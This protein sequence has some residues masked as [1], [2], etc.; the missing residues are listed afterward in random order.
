VRWCY[1]MG[2]PGRR[3]GFLAPAAP[4]RPIL[5]PAPDGPRWGL[6]PQTPIGLDGLVLKLPHSP[7]G[8]AV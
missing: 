5:G 3:R 4:T 2:E 8:E 7:L 6:R 1:H